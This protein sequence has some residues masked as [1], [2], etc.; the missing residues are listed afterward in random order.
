MGS[1]ALGVLTCLARRLGDVVSKKELLSEVWPDI[2]VDEAN[3]RYNI[4]ALRRALGEGEDGARYIINVP[5]RGYCLVGPPSSPTLPVAMPRNETLPELSYGFIGREDAI[6]VIEQQLRDQ[7]LVT[8]VGPGGIGKTS[9]AVAVSREM[10]AE[11]RDGVCFVDLSSVVDPGLVPSALAVALKVGVASDDRIGGVINH[12][13][14][15]DILIVLD[16]C[17]HV[18]DGAAG[19][20]ERILTAV[21]DVHLLAT[22][23]E[24]LRIAGERVYQLA[25]LECPPPASDLSKEELLAYPAPRLF[26]DRAAAGGIGFELSDADVARVAA[27]CADLDGLPLAIELAAARVTSFGVEGVATYVRQRFELLWPGRRTAP[28]R[29]RT[30]AAML[31]WSANLLT[32]SELVVMRRLSIL[33]GPFP[34]EAAEAIAT[35]NQLDART[36]V[37]AVTSLIAKSLVSADLAGA[38]P[39]FR[40]L[41]TTRHYFNERL[42]S[43]G[44]TDEIALRH[45]RFYC[46]LLRLLSKGGEAPDV[47]FNKHLGN[48]RSAL[49]W[50]FSERGDRVIGVEL[51]AA[52]TNFFLDRSLMV[53]CSHWAGLALKSIGSATPQRLEIELLTARGVALV[54]SFGNSSEIRAIFTRALELLEAS[55]DAQSKLRLLSGLYYFQVMTG[56]FRGTLTTSLE[57]KAICTGAVDLDGAI[58]ADWM[59][60]VAHHNLGNQEATRQF[61]QSALSPRWS[62]VPDKFGHLSGTNS[63]ISALVVL[64]RAYWLLGLQD[65]AATVARYSVKEAELLGLPMMHCITLLYAAHLHIWIEDWTSAESLVEQAFRLASQNSLGTHRAHATWLRGVIAIKRDDTGVCLGIFRR[66]LA[67]DAAFR[68]PLLD[69]VLF[70]ALAEGLAATGDH[71]GA[72]EAIDAALGQVNSQSESALMPEL[73]RIKGVILGLMGR[74]EAEKQL[75][76]AVSCAELHAALSWKL[77]AALSLAEFRSTRGQDEEA[78]ALL[79]ATLDQFTEGFDNADLIRAANFLGR[80]R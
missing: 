6:R 38:S 72:L 19:L 35:D 49:E 57:S 7:R 67:D 73:L 4:V 14:T 59:I 28:P 78:R 47:A 8:I 53:E 32:P 55:E 42:A 1:R 25:P 11:F 62:G 16:S 22:S 13:K 74:P 63:R 61:C 58:Q 20:A 52:A 69:T 50:A 27:I 43:S 26:A 34:M 54:F 40:L 79:A 64:A 66:S 70:C 46:G 51:A 31:D 21:P 75:L 2:H 30:L 56:D 76:E 9:V 60:G 3:L 37:D 33:V 15:R 80:R 41:D 71:S 45:A 10:A 12:L 29:H 65:K 39:W 23:R 18:I 5:G 48:I 77:R 17:E 44:E 36:V 68:Y 24:A